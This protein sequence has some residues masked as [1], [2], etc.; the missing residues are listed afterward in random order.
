MRWSAAGL[1]LALIPL[2]AL[3]RAEQPAPPTP[4]WIETLRPRLEAMTPQRPEEY[5]RLGEEVMD[6]AATPAQSELARTLLALAFE[7]DAGKSWISPSSCVALA[8]LTRDPAHR[9]WLW[10]VAISLDPR[11]APRSS[12]AEG[13]DPAAAY[14]AACVLGLVRSGE[15]VLARQL[16]REPQVRDLLT[17]LSPLLAR[18]GVEGGFAGLETQASRWPCRECQNARVVRRAH[19]SAE[20]RICPLCRGLPGP[21]LT[22]AQRL[23]QLRL[24]AWLLRGVPSSWAAQVTMDEG[25]PL[26][27][28]NPRRLPRL[29]GVDPARTIWRNGA[30]VAPPA[31]G[32]S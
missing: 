18:G 25:K 30:W 4:A 13:L 26:E 9:R 22:P 12:Q 10:A 11:Y 29:L 31:P 7:L 16:L 14:Q 6:G 20:Y 15:G 1:V 28:L 24:E 5:F 21:E 19:E 27:D 23:D 17:R 2:A 8:S 32:A 3:H